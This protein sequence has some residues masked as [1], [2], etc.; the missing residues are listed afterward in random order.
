MKASKVLRAIAVVYCAVLLLQQ[1]C[2]PERMD[3]LTLSNTSM[4]S[5]V[6]EPIVISR[7]QLADLFGEIPFGK[8][9]ELTDSTGTAIASQ[10]DD[11]NKDGIWDELVLVYSFKPKAAA[12]I[13]CRYVSPADLPVYTQRTNVRF[14]K[15]DGKGGYQEIKEETMPKDHTVERTLQRYQLE[16]PG[17]ENDKIGFRNYFDSRNAMDIFGKKTP[18]MILDKTDLDEKIAEYM[19]MQPWG[20]DILKVAGSLGAGGLAIYEADSLYR[21]TGAK[22]T[23]Y[24]LVSRGPV[25]SVFRLSYLSVPVGQYTYDVKQEITIWA[26]MS[27]Y[28]SK[29]WLSGFTGQKI[30][31]SG[32]A[33]IKPSTRFRVDSPVFTAIGT[34]GLQAESGDA[35]DM[36]LIVEKSHF[37]GDSGAALSGSGVTQ[38]YYAKILAKNN[39]PVTFYF[40]AG[41]AGQNPEYRHSPYF[42]HEIKQLQIRLAAPIK[43]FKHST[44]I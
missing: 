38:T 14:A 27:G 10:T 3:R 40:I 6:D 30:L 39:Q 13:N 29:V 8:V 17:W 28:Q 11:L 43:I 19:T 12:R 1:A 37:L 21:V 15:Q 20:M 7:Q 42:L 26:G 35:L 41:W 44:K 22:N 25:R 18:K 16:G 9:P 36:A 4:L 5:R 31:V 33:E 32:I 2:S 23:T 24:K 34:H